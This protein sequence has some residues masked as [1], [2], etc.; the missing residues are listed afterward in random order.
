M[1]KSSFAGMP[2]EALKF[3]RAL[4]KNNER[5]WFDKHKDDYLNFV[6]APMEQFTI[7]VSAEL[8]R[9]APEYATEPKQAM[10][11]IYRDTRFSANKTPYKT[12][13]SAL[14]FRPD[15]GKKEAA[16]FYVEISHKYVGVAGGLYWALP[17]L[18]QAVRSHLLDHH[19]QFTKMA[20]NKALVEL[21]GEVQGERLTRPPKG[22]LP[23]HPA[24]EWIK[25]KQWYFWKELDSDLATSPDLLPEVMKRM[26][27]MHPVLEFLNEPLMGKRKKSLPLIL[28]L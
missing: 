23:T 21:M 20:R 16:A 28:D 9:F 5:E 24:I 6:K 4:E 10:F 27:K 3:F 8:M 18:M 26:K 13:T 25:H 22:F 19:E 1:A 14:F 7:A 2:A 17:D 12:N 15:L 11:R